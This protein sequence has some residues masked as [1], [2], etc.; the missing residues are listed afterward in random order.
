M[1]VANINTQARLQAVLAL[2]AGKG[3]GQCKDN[4]SSY[5]GRGVNVEQST[6]LAD[7]PAK[8]ILT[9]VISLIVPRDRRSIEEDSTVVR[10]RTILKNNDAHATWHL[11]C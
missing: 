11:L 4:R 7:H 5:T 1:H 6:L 10:M 8:S 2:A 3:W 9:S